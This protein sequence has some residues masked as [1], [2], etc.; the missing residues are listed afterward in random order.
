VLGGGIG[1][2]RILGTFPH[3]LEIEGEL[4]T[5]GRIIPTT[6]W[7]ELW[8]AHAQWLGVEPE[9]MAGV[10]P[11]LQNFPAPLSEGQVYQ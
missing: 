6:S 8:H 2:G 3:S 11:N 5:R 10:L 7:E 4:T 1:G 9:L